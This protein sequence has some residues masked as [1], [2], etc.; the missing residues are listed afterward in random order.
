MKKKILLTS[1]TG[2]GCYLLAQALSVTPTE[3]SNDT[4]ATVAYGFLI[5]DES[6]PVGLYHFPATSASDPQMVAETAAVSAGA[7]ANGTYYAQTYSPGPYPLAW[8]TVDI[9]TGTITKIAD[10]DDEF[11][12][13]VDMT[14]DYSS[15]KLWG[16]YHYGG[17]STALV[18]INP[19][20]GRGDTF[21]EFEG[22]WVAALACSYEGDLYALCNDGNLYS[23]NKQ[24]K[25]LEK[26]GFTEYDIEYMQSME[27]DHET[28]ALYWAA[29]TT[30][31]GYLY[32]IDTKTG[33]GNY[34]STL[35]TDGEMTGLYIPFSLAEPDAPAAVK[36]L[37]IS[38]PGHDSN[39]TV[40]LTL[41]DK[42]VNG[43]ELTTITGVTLM[44]D[45][46]TAKTWSSDDAD[47][48]PGT[49]VELSAT[50][51][52]GFHSLKVY[53]SNGAGNGLPSTVKAFI[54]ED[55]PAAPSNITVSS[56]G[57][58]ATISWDA[59]TEGRQGG[60]ID[61]STLT[62][63][64]VRN[65][66]NVTIVSGKSQL[67]CQDTVDKMDI[68]T[69]S[70][71]ASTSK[72]AGETAESEKSV[73]GDGI[74]TPY[75]YDFEDADRLLLWDIIDSN[76]D[77][78]TWTR[79]STY[80]GERTMRMSG[81]NGRVVDD[82]LITP[83][84]KLNAD[85]SYKIKFNDGCL[86]PYYA[87]HYYITFGSSKDINSHTV[88]KE[89]NASNT[90]LRSNIIYLP[91]ITQNGNYYVGFHAQWESGLATLYVTNFTIEEN[92]AA[93]MTGTVTDGASPIAG[94]EVVFDSTDKYTTDENG[95]FEINEIEAGEHKIDVS[96]FGFET[97]S[98]TMAFN[99]LE[100]K[101]TNI[102]L[103]AIPT[104]AISGSVT[105]ISGRGI[106]NASVSLHGYDN[107]SAT[108]DKDGAFSIGGVYT[109]GEYVLDI[110]ALN[111]EAA[112]TV[113]NNLSSDMTLDPVT[114]N[115]KLIAPSNVT[116]AATRE[117]AD[118][119][120]DAPED[121]LSTFR[122]DDGT[123]NYVF[124][125]ELSDVSEYTA[126]GVIYD[127]PGVYTSMSWHIYDSSTYAETV[128]VIVFDLDEN[129]VPTNKIL[130]E[131]NGLPTDNWDW[132]ECI[133]K[134]PVV[135]PHG[136]L[137]TLRGDA[138]LCMDSAE[139]PEYPPMY[140]K[141][142][143]THDYRTEA[144]QSR[145]SDGLPA[146]RGNLLVRAQGYPDGAPRTQSIKTASSETGI[147]HTYNVY[148]F[149]EGYETNQS[150]W[151]LLTEAPISTTSYTDNGWSSLAK[152][153]Y[154]YAIKAI[155][156]DGESSYP[157][158]SEAVLNKLTSEVT[159]TFITNA[160]GETAAG[161]SVLLVSEDNTY[162]YS[163]TADDSGIA[164]IKDVH[165]G[166]YTV[167]CTKKGFDTYEST[168]SIN[169]E[170]D[171]SD[172]F[173]LT[174]SVSAPS[175]LVIEETGTATTRLLRW[176]VMQGIFEDFEGHEDWTINSPG[177]IGWSYIDGDG[178]P[179]YASPNYE[180]PNMYQPMAFIVMNPSQTDPS[181]L[182]ADFMNAYS[183]NKALV[184]WAVNSGYEANDDYII[185][186]ELSMP[187]DFVISFYARCYYSRY[188]E[189]IR[190][191]YSTSGKDKDNFIW[192]GDDI[193]VND[194]IWKQF[195]V[196]IPKEAKYVAINYISN[197]KYYL[198]LDDIFIGDADKIPGTTALTTL[199]AG[200]PTEYEVWLDG[201]K[202]GTTTATE[203]LLENLTEG[204]HTAGVK[205]VY[206]SG[207]TELS[208]IQ[209][210]VSLSG[211]ENISGARQVIYS[212]NGAIVVK[213]TSEG[214][215][216]EVYSTSGILVS[217]TTA[218][219]SLTRIPVSVGLYII[220]T[221]IVISRIAVN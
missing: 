36:D 187:S 213:G 172:T 185:S 204:S 173:T 33:E 125:M 112:T 221:G 150:E 160:P 136:A 107:Y 146:F 189:T 67:T 111:Y 72:G 181:M 161:A 74:E 16:V 141:M 55:T 51:A 2:I 71:T 89:V 106:E 184:A 157:T 174:E 176:N 10:C 80:S 183:G 128:D 217:R 41:P 120:W 122:Y 199:S 162:S 97:K 32:T 46:E 139:N 35:G 201:N 34:I 95:R 81:A 180:F 212:E 13:Y 148:R 54:G 205:S 159:L 57:L 11:P 48:T 50:V 9:S 105:D 206:A 102:E 108:T 17:T 202:L 24:S 5:N 20:T 77:G 96:K 127:T 73:I 40:S 115:V 15:G 104:A 66:G 211:V 4:E 131:E 163:A 196:N 192:I 151:T 87:A 53:A 175:N 216:V 65:P 118:L 83:P 88:I 164:I 91:E 126:V 101:Q 207:V 124:N 113:V 60:Y 18:D 168:I 68:Y 76:G 28:G 117:K 129:G 179:T 134:Y 203:Y 99:A 190:V 135:A 110:Y 188:I 220:K 8:N 130:Y 178:M 191:G 133:F 25:T 114:L 38:N 30:Y 156:A 27:F 103:A 153:I 84:I 56:N 6:R 219:S 200:T 3:A 143:F 147:S 12:L 194:E 165:E 82:W 116:A 22:S 100:H 140:D 167:T 44:C 1:L 119:A 158:L 109:T 182:E 169:G 142:V 149:T 26:I 61:Q 49:A 123:D 98:V 166:E 14:Y 69:Y 63:T 138:R 85:N 59:V 137:F 170:S 37:A 93:W 79:G 29:C 155:Y 78:F 186:P 121:K 94:A 154:R 58:S 214:E 208:T 23:V 52:E 42:K 92:Q 62:Y 132:W 171:F 144:F 210:E 21:A 195:T 86:N 177:E 145:L 209:F 75:S 39:I 197:D 47:L 90:D 198:A 31:G 45:D 70:V 64:V 152:G 43:G 193:T 218:Q 215:T 7:M 19:Q